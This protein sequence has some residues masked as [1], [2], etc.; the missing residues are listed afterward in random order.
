MKKLSLLSLSVAVALAGCGSDDDNGSS[1]A[2]ST[3][4]LTGFDGYFKNAVMFVDANNNGQLDIDS[5]NILGLTNE[6]GQVTV[7]ENSLSGVIALQTLTVGGDVQTKLANKDPQYAGVFTIDMDHAAQ[8]MQHEVVFRAPENSDVVSPI[9]DLVALEMS[10]NEDLTQQEAETNVNLAL[11]GTEE[12][13]ID[14]YA[15]FVEGDE[16]DAE[17]HKTAQILTESKAANPEMYE[18]HAIDYAQTATDEVEKMDPDQ[19]ED[20]NFKPVI[21]SD[22]KDDFVPVVVTNSKLAVDLETF[23]AVQQKL[24]AIE[25]E[26]N[27]DNFSQQ[28]SIKGLFTD[29][30][31]PDS[32]AVTVFDEEESLKQSGLIVH[33]INDLLSVVVP[34]SSKLSAGSHSFVLEAQD[35]DSD[36]K[37]KGT[38]YTDKLTV[39]V[40]TQ[41]QAPTVVESE[42]LRLQQNITDNWSFTQGES[43]E[44]T[45]LEVSQLFNDKDGDELEFD[46]ELSGMAGVSASIEDAL[47][48]LTGTPT[49][50]EQ[51]GTLTVFASDGNFAEDTQAGFT[52]PI[53]A[54]GNDQGEQHPLESS[55]WYLLE[56]GSGDGDGN[57]SNN[58]TRVWCDS[59]HLKDGVWY[60]NSRTTDNRTQCSTPDYNNGTPYEVING[61]IIATFQEDGESFELVLDK[62]AD[63][64]NIADDAVTVTWTEEGEG[65]RYVWFKDKADAEARIQ[66]ESQFDAE[67]RSFV[68]DLP[69]EKEMEYNTGFISV[70]LKGESDSSYPN[71]LFDADITFDV[72]NTDFTCDVLEEFYDSFFITGV[73]ANGQR[74]YSYSTAQSGLECYDNEENGVYYAG[75]DFD[76]QHQLKEG[77]VYSFIGKLKDDQAIFL[78]DIKFNVTWTGEGNND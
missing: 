36:L 77:N 45:T 74:F 27:G 6:K 39:T 40:H 26:V 22:S 64:D 53:V 28:I 65:S 31:Q 8:A 4:V 1:P 71:E 15:D 46:V 2:V 73:D 66:I 16:A 18:E 3:K 78:E 12:A 37:V 61:S 51:T 14:L 75:I 69:G 44:N 19:I 24:A 70:S 43:V 13:P 7:S 56:R 54:K 49:T 47:I 60:F 62:V 29:E 20:D 72:P 68:M 21:E 33:V 63:S 34:D 50:V 5:D 38:V 35:L 30:D 57:D 67:K 23:K 9:T 32:I 55:V 17:L 76:I 10:K 41:N 48:T 42:K 58:Y 52:L 11:G 59:V 25:L